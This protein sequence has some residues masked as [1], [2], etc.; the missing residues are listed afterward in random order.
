ML[1]FLVRHAHAEPG[2]P[3]ETRPLSER[4]RSE[5]RVLAESLSKHATPPVSVVTSPLLRARQTADAIAAATGAVLRVDERL[6]P[7]ASLELLREMAADEASPLVAV[8]HQP[9]CSEIAL[10][11]TG[12]DP[13]FPPGGVAELTLDE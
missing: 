13:G 2:D 5:A 3:D 6:A 9:D 8:C 1:L 11:L 4:G 7:G 10:E 12:N